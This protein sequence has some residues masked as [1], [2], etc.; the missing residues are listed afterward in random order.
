[1]PTSK[2]RAALAAWLAQ[3]EEV[4]REG[5]QPDSAQ[6]SDEPVEHGDAA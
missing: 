5:G 2:A 6:E 1:M 4:L 3:A